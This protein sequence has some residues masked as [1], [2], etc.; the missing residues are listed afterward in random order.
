MRTVTGLVSVAL[1]LCQEGKIIPLNKYSWVPN[2]G[3]GRL[4]CYNRQTKNILSQ[5]KEKF[6]F[7][8]RRSPEHVVSQLEVENGGDVMIAL[9]FS[10]IDF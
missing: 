6:I 2:L 5:T 4:R 1:L 9:S 10:V 8:L 3:L 7:L